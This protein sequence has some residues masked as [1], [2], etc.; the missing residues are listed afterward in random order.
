MIQLV[1]TLVVTTLVH[2][3]P[4]VVTL[5]VF[6]PPWRPFFA[7][8]VQRRILKLIFGNL[9][10]QMQLAWKGCKKHIET[11]RN[12][13]NLAVLG[14]LMLHLSISKFIPVSAIEFQAFHSGTL[15]H[16]QA[17][18]IIPKTWHHFFL[19]LPCQ[20]S[21]CRHPAAD[22]PVRNLTVSSCN[23]IVAK[24]ALPIFRS[25]AMQL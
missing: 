7:S 3:L 11:S 12:T 10:N 15:R 24:Q 13:M 1:V 23:F 20:M 2:M 25:F 4:H 16:S 22:A 8:V 21:I 6:G 18:Q 19:F 17:Y 9:C 5:F 14:K